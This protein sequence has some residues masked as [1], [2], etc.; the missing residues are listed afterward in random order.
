M[1]DFIEK[2]LTQFINGLILRDFGWKRSFRRLNSEQILQWR[3]P[4]S[5]HWYSEKTALRL[6]KIQALDHLEDH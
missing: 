5:G 6:V 1:Y 4:N 3:D 2:K